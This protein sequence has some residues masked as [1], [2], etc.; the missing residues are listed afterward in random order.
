MPKKSDSGA[1]AVESEQTSESQI[2]VHWREEEYFFPSAKF[3]GQANASDPSIRDRFSEDKFPECFKEYADLLVLGYLLAHDAR[4]QQRTVLEVVRRWSPQ[5]LVQLRR[6]PPAP[7]TATRRRSSGF[8]NPRTRPSR[9]SPIRSST[10]GSTS[11]PRCSG[12]SADS[13]PATW[14]TF[15]MP[16]VPD[17][18]VA[19]LACARLGVIHSQVFGG[20]SGAACGGPYRRLQEQNSRHH[21]RLLPQRRAARP[22]G[23]GR[24]S[25][26]AS[27]RGGRRWSTR[28]W[29]FGAIPASTLEELRWSRARLLRRRGPAR[30]Q[31]A[32]GRSRVDA[33]GGAAVHHVLQRH[34]GQAQGLSAQHGRLPL[35]R[36]R[37]VEVLPGHPPRGHLLVRRRHRLDH[38]ALLHRLRA[39]GARHDDG[40]VRG[41]ADVSR[42]RAAVGGSPNDWA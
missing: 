22:Q 31:E 35:L 4:H 19:M 2:A 23:K 14:S 42:R 3:I 38:R 10:Y 7:P 17:L 39:V 24:R 25:R 11:S 37:N 13:R 41:R 6:P 16:M 32:A 34:D 28:S 5:R 29:S 26:C 27:P 33:G 1:E 12:I 20:F 15:H 21:G 36:D 18:P 8:P 30:L 40:D 9:R